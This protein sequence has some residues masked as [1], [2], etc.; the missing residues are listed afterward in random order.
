MIIKSTSHGAL[1]GFLIS[2]NVH[3]GACSHHNLVWK[4][5]D[6]LE[7]METRAKLKTIGKLIIKICDYLALLVVLP[8]DAAERWTYKVLEKR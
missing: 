2:D 4:S 1:Y 6:I 8:Y 7:I 3:E 5:L